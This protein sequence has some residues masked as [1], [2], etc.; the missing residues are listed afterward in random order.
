MSCREWRHRYFKRSYLFLLWITLQ[1]E[2]Y[3]SFRTAWGLSHVSHCK[4]MIRN[5]LVQPDVVFDFESN[6]CNL[7]SVAPP[8]GEKEI[9]FVLLIRAS[10]YLKKSGKNAYAYSW[11]HF[12]KKWKQFFSRHQVALDSW[13]YDHSTQN[14]KLHQA[15]VTV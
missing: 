1:Y 8:G 7:S 4:P 5:Q 6:A 12:V 11:R 15:V 9:I 10:N 3:Y 13:N 2:S 14:Q